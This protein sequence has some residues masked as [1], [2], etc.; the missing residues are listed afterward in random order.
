M[1]ELADEFMSSSEKAFFESVIAKNVDRAKQL[2]LYEDDA[3]F[4]AKRDRTVIDHQAVQY[5]S[6]ALRQAVPL[7]KSDLTL[8]LASVFYEVM[9]A[10]QESILADAPRS[11]LNV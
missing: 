1:M 5:I 2:G 9:P 6:D 4:T 11:A 8:I 7:L 10:H 3:G